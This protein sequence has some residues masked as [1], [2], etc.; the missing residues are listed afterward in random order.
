MGSIRSATGRHLI[1]G[2]QNSGRSPMAKPRLTAKRFI[3]DLVKDGVVRTGLTEEQRERA[4]KRLSAAIRQ[5]RSTKRLYKNGFPTDRKPGVRKLNN[6]VKAGEQLIKAMYDVPEI[7]LPSLNHGMRLAP[8]DPAGA[9]ES[10]SYENLILHIIAPAK[11]MLKLQPRRV[12]RWEKIGPDGKVRRP[13]GEHHRVFLMALFDLLFELTGKYPKLW[14]H[15]DSTS[16]AKSR[17]SDAYKLVGDR[18]PS[19]RT[20]KTIKAEW[21]SARHR[22]K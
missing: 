17:F 2:V 5:Y 19:L 3:D 7:Y 16:K 4:T 10:Y 1:S 6:V 11:G 13:A 14:W 18:R 15:D 9:V 22:A 20:L 12:A 21:K 8:V